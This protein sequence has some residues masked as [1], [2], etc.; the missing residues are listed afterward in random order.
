[1]AWHRFR[2]GQ[3]KGELARLVQAAED[4]LGSNRDS[5]VLVVFESLHFHHFRIPLADVARLLGQ[6]L[7]VLQDRG[8]IV[9]QYH[10]DLPFLGEEDTRFV[11]DPAEVLWSV[12]TSY[13]VLSNADSE[14]SGNTRVAEASLGLKKP[15]GKIVHEARR[16]LVAIAGRQLMHSPPIPQTAM[17]RWSGLKVLGIQ[18]PAQAAAKSSAAAPM[19]RPPPCRQR[20]PA[21]A[22]LPQPESSFNLS[23]T[24]QQRAARDRVVLPFMKAQTEGYTIEYT[25]G[26]DEGED[27]DGDLE[28]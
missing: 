13:V 20:S 5:R 14:R 18:P 11:Y 21:N 6:L 15:S 17:V 2:G 7:N 8:R 1:M 23:L 3:A 28:V 9:A 25:A 10:S 19:V 4:I 24:E 27:P 22:L 26:S 12:A 16:H